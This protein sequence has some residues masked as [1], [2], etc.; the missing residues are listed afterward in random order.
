VPDWKDFDFLDQI[1]PVRGGMRNFE[2]K[3]V[4]M[5]ASIYI[6]KFSGLGVILAL[7]LLASGCASSETRGIRCKSVTYL[8]LAQP[9]RVLP[10]LLE[11]HLCPECKTDIRRIR[12]GKT[13]Q[14]KITY[15]CEKCG[16]DSMLCCA[17]APRSAPIQGME[18]K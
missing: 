15:V 12:V 6:V 10:A 17:T 8:N 3:G 11:D 5:K 1:Q 2:Q 4:A 7:A 9:G 18:K 13:H 16:E 14:V